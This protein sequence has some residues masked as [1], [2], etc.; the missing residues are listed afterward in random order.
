MSSPVPAVRP[1][2]PIPANNKAYPRLAQDPILSGMAV[3]DPAEIAGE[4]RVDYE[5][6]DI[7]ARYDQWNR[8][9]AR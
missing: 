6:V 1:G 9:V 4:Y 5:K 8:S 3:L 7:P 2:R